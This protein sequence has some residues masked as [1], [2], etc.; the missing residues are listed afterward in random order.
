MSKDLGAR[1]AEQLVTT[2]RANNKNESSQEKTIKRFFSFYEPVPLSHRPFP[3]F[4][5]SVGMRFYEIQKAIYKRH[6][7]RRYAGPSPKRTRISNLGS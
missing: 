7:E 6:L 2:K 4:S 1:N 3:I 5:L